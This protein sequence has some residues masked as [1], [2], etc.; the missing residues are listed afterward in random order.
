MAQ[1]NDEQIDALKFVSAVG[2]AAEV[3]H[4]LQDA[5]VSLF[6]GGNPQWNMAS[7]SYSVFIILCFFGGCAV[8]SR[9]LHE[10]YW[11]CVGPRAG[12]SSKTPEKWLDFNLLIFS[13]L[14]HFLLQVGFVLR[15]YALPV[16]LGRCPRMGEGDLNRRS[17][18]LKG[19]SVSQSAVAGSPS[20]ACEGILSAWGRPMASILAAYTKQSALRFAQVGLEWLNKEV[21]PPNTTLCRFRL[22]ITFWAAQPVCSN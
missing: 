16:C 12:D 11:M 21:P 14:P 3:C 1:Q 19:C 2:V 20:P 22:E 18:T 9:I 6:I 15:L 5:S 7:K 4:H 10:V 13:A 17:Y 8:F